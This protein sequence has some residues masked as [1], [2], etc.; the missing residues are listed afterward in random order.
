[1]DHYLYFKMKVDLKGQGHRFHHK[2]WKITQKKKIIRNQGLIV[3]HS[4]SVWYYYGFFFLIPSESLPW[5]SKFKVTGATTNIEK[6]I[7]NQG[8]IVGYLYL[9]W[10][11]YGQYS[12][13][14]IES[15]FWRSKVKVTLTGTSTTIKKIQSLIVRHSYS[16][17]WTVYFQ[18]MFS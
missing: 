15:W 3:G 4:F 2:L 7:N 10:Y 13:I 1:M 17:W 14:Q 18:K 6:I 11:N 9:V 5:R 12:S 8:L 16:A